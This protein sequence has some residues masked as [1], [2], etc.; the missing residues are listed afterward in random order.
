MYCLKLNFQ[1]AGL[2][3]WN[4]IQTQF[5][6]AITKLADFQGVNYAINKSPVFIIIYMFKITLVSRIY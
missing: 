2:L 5:W 6:E 4:D 1:C 3:I